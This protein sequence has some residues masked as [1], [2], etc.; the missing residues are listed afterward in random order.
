M[1]VECLKLSP[2]AG[3]RDRTTAF[4]EGL[5][6]ILGPNEA[7]KSTLFHALR[8]L[9]F[10]PGSLTPAVFR[11][12]MG[13]FLP[14]SGGDFIC[15]EGEFSVEGVKFVLR[16]TWKEKGGESELR[17]GNAVFHDEV[18]ISDAVAKALGANEAAWRQVMLQPQGDLGRTIAAL[19]ER[20]N[21][22][23]MNA[24]ADL[25][26]GVSA[27]SGG[28]STAGFMERLSTKVSE[29]FDKW[30]T[31]DGRPEKTQ[32]GQYYRKGIGLVYGA[33]LAADDAEERLRAA[34]RFE[35]QFDSVNA[36]ISK[37]EAEREADRAFLENNETAVADARKRRELAAEV[38]AFDLKLKEIMRVSEDWPVQEEIIRRIEGGLEARNQEIQDL[39]RELESATRAGEFASLREKLR[40]IAAAE[41]ELEI[42]RSE[43]SGKPSVPPDE[44]KKALAAFSDVER[45]RDVAEGAVMELR[46][47]S[48]DALEAEFYPGLSDAESVS[49]SSGKPFERQVNG[50]FR[51][52]SCGWTLSVHAGAS[53]SALASRAGEA[54]TFLRAF[55]E[56]YGFADRTALE[57]H[58]RWRNQWE[59]RTASQTSA[60]ES[61]LEGST[62]Q[63]VEEK[64]ASAPPEGSTRPRDAVNADLRRKTEQLARDRKDVE[65]SRK[66]VS[67]YRDAW[68]D[69]EA[70]FIASSE[71]VGAKRE[72]ESHIAA[73]RP[74]PE[75]FRDDAEFLAEFEKRRERERTALEKIAQE[76]RELSE[77]LRVAPPASAEEIQRELDDRKAD[78]ERVKTDG[79]AWLSVLAAATH[80]SESGGTDASE[81]LRK[82]LIRYMSLLTGGRYSDLRLEKSLPS[83]LRSESGAEL[84]PEQLSAGTGD[85]LGLAL[86]FAMADHFLG[87]SDGFLVLDDPLVDMDPDRQA[88][89]ARLIRGY[90]EKKQILLF[91][92]HPSHADL[93]GGNAIPLKG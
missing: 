84:T 7:G 25:L 22:D 6:V 8:S 36:R 32:A 47:E 52:R 57:T 77:L 29:Y 72:T 48:G 64:L 17:T 19:R 81:S 65:S 34:V 37:L 10:V 61:L 35:T 39:D 2:F 83:A 73:L 16:R 5:N 33:F 38:A 46:L 14:R 21:A 74:L 18:S 51:I 53:L 12:E 20:E 62:R 44:L 56:K 9:L 70:L 82:P 58:E 11:R 75:S 40:R 43:A 45:Y 31:R 4:H 55:A 91:T 93:L 54:E 59:K 60:L 76:N 90:A 50:S 71:L 24:L 63:S 92:C 27:M 23:A 3:S 28:I 41:K 42:L 79:A 89:A 69:R 80:A 15:A 78:L 88:A 87:D 13:R 85:S 26:S 86:R 67:E 30:N 68:K 49:V 66:R 1:R